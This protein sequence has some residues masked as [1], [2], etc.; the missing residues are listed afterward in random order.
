MTHLRLSPRPHDGGL[1]HS[2]LLPCW[3]RGIKGPYSLERDGP[4]A[5]HLPVDDVVQGNGLPVAVKINLLPKL[6]GEIHSLQVGEQLERASE[7]SMSSRQPCSQN[8]SNSGVCAYMC[9]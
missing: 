3:S 4:L 7:M 5:V 2:E 1:V 6:G 8:R 9:T